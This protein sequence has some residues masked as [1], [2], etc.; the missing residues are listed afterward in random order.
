[1]KRFKSIMECDFSSKSVMAILAATTIPAIRLEWTTIEDIF[2]NAICRKQVTDTL[3]H[4]MRKVD[5]TGQQHIHFF[6][7]EYRFL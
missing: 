6:P 4:E 5:Y 7:F 3:A 1:M 2:D